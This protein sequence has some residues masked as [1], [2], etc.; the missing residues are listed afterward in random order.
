MTPRTAPAALSPSS[1]T[2]SRTSCAVRVS[3]S[4]AE[5]TCS[6][7]ARASDSST[8]EEPNASSGISRASTKHLGPQLLTL[9]TVEPLQERLDVLRQFERVERLHDVAD[10]AELV[11]A[12]S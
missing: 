9:S 1:S 10:R 12:L 6:R 3:A 4:L 8:P 11:G 7:R 2:A 5:T